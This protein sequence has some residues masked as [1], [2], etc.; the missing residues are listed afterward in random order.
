MDARRGAP[1]YQCAQ[2]TRRYLGEFGQWLSQ[3]INIL[4]R[5]LRLTKAKS[6]LG[7]VPGRRRVQQDLELAM[8]ASLVTVHV[9][10]PPTASDEND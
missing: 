8:N 2:S 5:R 1:S 4:M 6:G 3:T 10:D 9:I 7:S